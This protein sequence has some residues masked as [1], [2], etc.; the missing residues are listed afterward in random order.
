MNALYSFVPP[1]RSVVSLLLLNGLLE[2]GG[3]AI[4]LLQQSARH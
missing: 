1:L 2:L 3:V 4:L